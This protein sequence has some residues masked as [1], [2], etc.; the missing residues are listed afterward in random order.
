LLPVLPVYSVELEAICSLEPGFVLH[1]EKMERLKTSEENVCVRT[2]E[3]NGGYWGR[4]KQCPTVCV[5]ELQ[6]RIYVFL[7]NNQK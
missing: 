5:K 7:L 1:T 3:P 4:G 6:G 2:M